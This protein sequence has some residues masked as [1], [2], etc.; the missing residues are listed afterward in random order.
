MTQPPDIL[1]PVPELYSNRGKKADGW[2]DPY[3]AIYVAAAYARRALSNQYTMRACWQHGCMG[4]WEAVAPEALTCSTPPSLGSRIFVAREEQ[5]EYLRSHGYSRARAIGLPILYTSPTGLARIPGSLLVVPTHTLPGARYDDRRPFEAYADLIKAA[6]TRFARVVVCVHPCCAGNGLWIDEFRSRNIDLVTGAMATDRHALKRMRALFEQFEY[7]TTNGW[8]SHIAYALAFGAKVSIFGPE[9]S[10]SEEDE[11]NAKND[12]TWVANPGAWNAMCSPEVR[13]RRREFLDRLY[14]EPHEGIH[15]PAWGDWLLG[16]AHQLSPEEMASTLP[17]IVDTGDASDCGAAGE[18]PAAFAV[19]G[20]YQLAMLAAE[21]RVREGHLQEAIAQIQI[22]MTS[23]PT[24]ACVLRAR[25]VLDLLRASASANPSGTTAAAAAADDFFG[26]GEVETIEHLVAAFTGDP[27]DPRALD[28]LISLQQGLVK[29]LVTAEGGSLESLFKGSFGRVYRALARSG[30]PSECPA[31][32]ARS[33]LAVLDEALGVPEGPAQRFD[34]RPL[35]ARMLLAPAHH[36]SV[37]ITPER[38]PAWLLEDYLG[39]VLNAPQVF[40][41]E[42]EAGRYHSHMLAWVRAIH[43]RIRAKPNDPLTTSIAT[44]FAMHANY[45]PLYLSRG[46][47]REL[48]EGRAAIIEF[49]LRKRGAAIDAKLPR[50]PKE[51]TRIKIGYLSAHFGAQTETHVTL[52]A[53]KLDR[54]KFEVCLFP[55]ARNGGPI[56]DYCRSLAD[57]FTL[58]PRDLPQ[59]VRT[60]REAALDVLIIGTNITAV[61]NQ[62]LLI[63]LHRLAPLQLVNYCSPGS[64]GIRNVDGYLTGTLNAAPNLQAHFSETLRFCEGPPGCLDYT[65]EA[66]GTSGPFD[67][68]ALGLG[69]DEVVFVNAAACFK[70]LPEMQELWAKI[71]KAVPKS[72]LLL[73][74]FN[75]NWSRRFP[76]KQFERTLTEAFA[77]QGLTRDRF[78]MANSQPSRADVKALERVTDVYLDTFPFS[79]SIS[80]VDPLELGIPCVV[81]EGETHRSRMA[82][83]LVRDLG[84]GEL[85]ATDADSYVQ[86][87]VN[88]GTDPDR[89]HRLGQEILRQMGL[90]PRFL[91]PSAY[92]KQLGELLE[93]LVSGNG[94]NAPGSEGVQSGP[95]VRAALQPELA[96][97]R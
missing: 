18:S 64:T 87:A 39:Y 20:Q 90:R 16:A 41:A 9:I 23:A 53:L 28:P 86:I 58:L 3:G 94:R 5:A 97:R 34:I 43:Q 1:L 59:Q 21:K 52:P 37:T 12:V 46:N 42:G 62:V 89:R 96:N 8:G 4:P 75:P 67:R 32:A 92:G 70:I 10:L 30:L 50:R 93:D 84:V 31:E 56:E 76:V 27:A 54:S 2:S 80:V 48:A 82:A 17:E 78:I 51:R 74:P 95:V 24:P 36:G 71:L 49:V 85:I 13:G 19:P 45:I 91:N 14:R 79:G 73:L 81:W 26:A 60:I 65:V 40:I 61:T 63:A 38:I 83:A 25:E 66:K 22:A 55:L 15:D 47:T 11:K 57:S 69:A 44:F 29:F 68:A 6:A 88:L 33:Q 72:R 77:R 7:V 35:L